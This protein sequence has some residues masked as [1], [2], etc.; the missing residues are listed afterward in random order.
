M[1]G[2]GMGLF[3]LDAG[4]RRLRDTGIN[5]CV[6]DWTGLLTFYGKAGF[7]PYHMWTVFWKNVG[8]NGSTSG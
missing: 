1:R 8:D 3:L 5:G 6:I 4:L 7:S 2:Q